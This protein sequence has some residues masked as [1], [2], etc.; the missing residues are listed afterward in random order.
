MIAFAA[1]VGKVPDR[2]VAYSKLSASETGWLVP[3]LATC[4]SALLPLV[5]EMLCA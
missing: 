2:E 5:S 1:Y 3:L 4:N